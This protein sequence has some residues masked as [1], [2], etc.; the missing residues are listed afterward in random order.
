M[1]QLSFKL[2]H[3]SGPSSGPLRHTGI[4]TR[5]VVACLGISAAAVAIFD[6]ATVYRGGGLDS[7]DTF[8]VVTLPVLT[9]ISII[10]LWLEAIGR[11]SAVSI[12]DAEIVLT[13]SNGRTRSFRWDQLRGTLQLWDMRRLGDG[14]SPFVANWGSTLQ[15]SLSAEAAQAI[16]ERAL[17]LGFT[18]RD[19]P[20][21]GTS[22]LASIIELRLPQHQN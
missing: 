21:A 9:A 19:I 3:G 20:H 16:R 12:S 18:E 5:L 1:E 6:A 11:P 17:S 8:L 22:R 10:P 7:I 15:F 13:Y 4:L 14:G 2:G